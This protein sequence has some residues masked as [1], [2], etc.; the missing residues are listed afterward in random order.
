MTKNW[1]YTALLSVAISHLFVS[2]E[3]EV[4][5][6][7][8][9]DPVA[10][11]N[12]Y[13]NTW[14]YS[15]VMSVYYLWNDKMGA[16]PNNTLNPDA[17]FNSIL[18]KFD[19]DLAPDGDRFSWIQENYLD[20]L[21]SLSGVASNELG[22]EY[23][24]YAYNEHE[25]FGEFAY[26][27]KDTD[28]ATKDFKRGQ[29]FTHVNNTSLTI[30]NYRTVL[31]N[32]TRNTNVTLKVWDVS[33]DLDAKRIYFDN[34][35]NITLNLSN[36]Y[37]EN[38]ILLDSIYTI[39]GKT[40]GYLVYNFF[41]P[42]SGDETGAYDVALNN[43]MGRFRTRGV[44]HLILDLRYNSG[45]R[46][47]SAIYLSS[48][49]VTNLN[50]SN[51][52]CKV[53]YNKEYNKWLVDNYGTEFL[54]DKFTDKVVV[55]DRDGKVKN[56]FDLNNI[57]NLQNVTILTGSGTASASEMVINGLKPYMDIFLIGAVTVGKNVASASFYKENDSKNKWGIQPI[58]AK[59]FNSRGESDFASGFTPDYIDSDDWNMP[60][61][62]LG[63]IN[64][65]LLGAAIRHISGETLTKT[66][67]TR[68]LQPAPAFLR[69][70]GSSFG[71]K[72]WNNQI[73]TNVPLP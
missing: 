5:P 10:A 32:A 72:A 37:A 56:T 11:A 44:N 66:F 27:K 38:P 51:V 28:A 67:Q 30:D 46:V 15:D 12:K 50:T 41:S 55:H 48:M 64:E 17:F 65:A 1:F 4:V 62:E 3:K 31:S 57:G 49:I 2:C 26:I 43:V 34:E 42:D 23:Q 36:K 40:I 20:L 21:A 7:N 13:V 68:S 9:D 16:N 69:E 70:V 22:F 53:E 45:G 73:I 19:K 54:I 61:K 14:I 52:F 29:A 24:L 39:N 71:N 33:I 25:V 18:Y 58:I 60:K 6:E 47:S 63:D 8:P 35:Q 59:Y